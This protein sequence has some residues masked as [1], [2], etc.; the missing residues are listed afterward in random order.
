MKTGPID[1]QF[2]K[3]IQEARGAS[4]LSQSQIAAFMTG[5]GF[6]WHQQTIARAENG[7]RCVS[8]GE[9][10]A[11]TVILRLDA[12]F[13]RLGAELPQLCGTCGDKPAAGFTCNTCGRSGP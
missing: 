2:A 6:P 12:D 1:R 8:V 13:S 5:Y 4:G 7:E 9:A 10:V 3:V 11:L